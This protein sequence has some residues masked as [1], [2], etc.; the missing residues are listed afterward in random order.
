MALGGE[1]GYVLNHGIPCLALLLLG[2]AKKPTLYVVASLVLPLSLWFVVGLG[3]TVGGGDASALRA[4][5]GSSPAVAWPK[6][7]LW[8]ALDRFL[9]V[10]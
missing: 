7:C 9:T 3:L 5:P 10:A 6:T 1:G 8:N 2:T 4:I